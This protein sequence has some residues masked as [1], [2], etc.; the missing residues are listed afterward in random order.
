MLQAAAVAVAAADRVEN[1]SGHAIGLMSHITSLTSNVL[2]IRLHNK[3]CS[4]Q[5]HIY[6]LSLQ[7]LEFKCVSLSN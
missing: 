6:V 7:V 3:T 1:E 2:N 4:Q 5:P